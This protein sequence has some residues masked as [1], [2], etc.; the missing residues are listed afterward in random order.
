MV[1]TVNK[2]KNHFR[3]F[4]EK[5]AEHIRFMWKEYTESLKNNGGQQFENDYGSEAVDVLTESFRRLNNKNNGFSTA[6]ELEASELYA[7]AAEDIAYNGYQK[8]KKYKEKNVVKQVGKGGVRGMALLWNGVVDMGRGAIDPENWSYVA[9]LMGSI[10]DGLK[11]GDRDRSWQNYWK[12]VKRQGIRGDKGFHNAWGRLVLEEQELDRF[13]HS[14]GYDRG[15]YDVE[16]AGMGSIK[17][18]KIPFLN[19]DLGMAGAAA[20]IAMQEL[21]TMGPLA[22]GKL[23]RANKVAKYFANKAGGSVK[24]G[25]MTKDGY[26]SGKVRTELGDEKDIKKAIDEQNVEYDNYLKALDAEPVKDQKRMSE[27]LK[28]NQ[29]KGKALKFGGGAYAEAEILT[30]AGAVAGGIWFQSMFGREASIIGEVGGGFFGPGIIARGSRNMLDWFSY[31]SFKLPGSRDTK[32]LRALKAM[33][34]SEDEILK[35]PSKKKAKLIS[36]VRAA[37][38]PRWTLFQSKERKRIL[39]M[40]HWDKEFESLPDDIRDPLMERT[41]AI[42]QLVA[43]FDTQVGGTGKLFTTID[44][45]FDMAWIASLRTL[46]R[47][48]KTIGHGVKVR[49]DI[50]EMQLQR[51]EMDVAR[52]LNKLLGELSDKKY[53]NTDFGLLLHSMDTQLKR[54]V[55]NLAKGKGQIAD[56]AREIKK[57]VNKR[58][59][60]NLEQMTDY[61]DVSGIRNNWDEGVELYKAGDPDNLKLTKFD[62]MASDE[63]AR[64]FS[65][66][67]NPMVEA[68]LQRQGMRL[69]EQGG[70]RV[71]MPTTR[72]TYKQS[73]RYANDSEKMFKELYDADRQYGSA[74]YDNIDGFNMSPARA[75]EGESVAIDSERLNQMT[76]RIG[77]ELAEFAEDNPRLATRIISNIRGKDVDV[78][79]FLA[80]ER[81]KA[82]KK[83]HANVGDD[84]YFELLDDLNNQ[85]DNPYELDLEKAD[86]FTN[87]MTRDME[88]M[89]NLEKIIAAEI[90]LVLPSD[91]VKLDISLSD[92][93]SMRSGLWKKAM[94]QMTSDIQRVSGGFNTRVASIIQRELDGF[95]NLKD[96]NQVW[97]TQVGEKWRKGTG[98]NIVNGLREPEEFF[99]TFIKSRTPLRARQD[100]DNIFMG[101]DGAY[102]EEVVDGLQFT[103]NQMLENNEQIPIT[104]WRNFGEEVLGWKSIQG[105]DS[106]QYAQSMNRK[107]SERQAKYRSD[108]EGI[109]EEIGKDID[110]TSARLQGDLELDLYNFEG[111]SLAKMEG[112][113]GKR[114]VD[115]ESLR[116]AI[117][118]ESHTGGDSRKLRALVK[119]I[120]DAPPEAAKK[121]K[122]TL[123]KILHEGAMEEAYGLRGTKGLGYESADVKLLPDGTKQ[124]E[125][126]R[127]YEEME[128]DSSALQLYITRNAAILEEIMEPKQ[129]KD[130]A[131]LS[132]LVTLVTGEIGSQAIENF[133]RGM[134]LQSLMSRAYGVAR[135]VIS[136]RYVLTELLIQHARFGRGKMITDLATDPDAFELLSD[137][138][139]R[140]GLTKPR[141]RT[142]FVEYFYGALLR[143]GR[144]MFE[145]EGAG[146]LQTMSENA[147][148]QAGGGNR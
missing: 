141:I 16:K 123:Q 67:R 89:A 28:V 8:Q 82:L 121:N 58:Y 56:Q 77:K 112:L 2:N 90:D 115:K 96:A 140:D 117:I 52:E 122:T 107:M 37:P 43:R 92:L 39:Q 144:D 124:L 71:L 12:D 113:F 86:E 54:N 85:L 105:E 120:K 106:I 5:E 83:T 146:D 81:L 41:D 57:S 38:L 100:F 21:L 84:E 137:V 95:D 127:L 31:L 126:G 19:E 33:G 102:D 145:A 26:R 18:D 142:E 101:A 72:T 68:A 22:L 65:D 131:D 9:E 32:N 148:N 15:I 133:P 75:K 7:D 49:F 128:V 139:L 66:T 114:I 109:T 70:R 29:T 1:E 129:L 69:V 130:L 34:Y 134:K 135:G 23:W 47:N 6:A 61:T 20:E 119:L 110:A 136:P 78:S 27:L 44:R 73:Q 138:I 103:V 11:L 30:S 74:Q 91:M 147:W 35:M 80:N 10:N 87:A 17:F 108:A 13:R 48:K 111:I 42:K 4:S 53:G 60:A 97:K 98:R 14:L 3:E 55:D 132:A 116:K 36:A 64:I 76:V 79:S 63:L 25:R 88:G 125:P 93:H 59:D 104:F 94:G 143:I 24:R 99:K 51:R 46:V 40:R 45:A 118:E 50:D 62:Q